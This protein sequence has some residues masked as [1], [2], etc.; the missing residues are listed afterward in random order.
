VS[1]ALFEQFKAR[2]TLQ[3]RTLGVNYASAVDTSL[4]DAYIKRFESKFPSATGFEGFENNYDAMYYLLYAFVGAGNVAAYTGAD[5]AR[6]MTRLLS[7]LKIDVDPAQISTGTAALQN[8]TTKIELHGTMG[9][10][11]FDPGSGA[12][13]S[14]GSVWCVDASAE[15]VDDALRLDETK[16]QL[17]GDFTCFAF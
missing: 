2:P 14:E 17:V 7:G 9:P 5:L 11:N 3:T 8:P 13:Q 4:R 6:G 16:E 12:R 1:K 15:A 10:P